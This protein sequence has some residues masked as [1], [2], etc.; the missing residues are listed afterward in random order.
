MDPLKICE[1]LCV[2]RGIGYEVEASEMSVPE[3]KR[4]AL[5]DCLKNCLRPHHCGHSGDG[6]VP[7]HSLAFSKTWTNCNGIKENRVVEIPHA[8]HRACLRDPRFLSLLLRETCV[9]AALTGTEE[10]EQRRIGY[11]SVRVISANVQL[12]EH[13]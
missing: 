5:K 8:E 10:E 13:A 6:T 12:G 1:P 9:V 7:Y 4:D 2:D 3:E 11:L